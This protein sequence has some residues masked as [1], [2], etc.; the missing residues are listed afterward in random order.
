M[1][2]I[3]KDKENKIVLTL[4]ESS[5]LGNAHYLFIF[6]NE[7]NGTSIEIPYT[8]DDESPNGMR[9]NIFQLEESVSGSTTGGTSVALSL[10]AGQYE[11]TVYESSAST[12][13]ISATTGQIIERGKMVVADLTNTYVNQIIP[14]QNNNNNS[15]YD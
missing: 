10:M 7:Y 4:S 8:T 2:Y 3:E 12:L 14:S 13:S 5:R 15:I 9:Y 1:I 6:K 11:Y